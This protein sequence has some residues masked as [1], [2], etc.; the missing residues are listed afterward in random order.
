MYEARIIFT[1]DTVCPWTYIAKKK[2]DQALAQFRS[3]PASSSITYTLHFEPYQLSPSFPPGSVDR[4]EWHFEHKHKGM[5]EAEDAFQSQL[6]RRA[7]PVG[8]NFRFDGA[9]GN[10]LHAHRVIQYFQQAKGSETANKLIDALYT[11]Y[12]EQGL[13]PSE[14]ETLIASCIEAGISEEEAKKVVLDKELGLAEVQTKLNEVRRDIDA[15]PVAAIEGKKRD[16]T[17]TGSKEIEEYLRALERIA[18]ESS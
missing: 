8:I 18:K 9:M 11:R 16:I 10:T 1:L 7:E 12:F 6:R 4:K 2:L 15:V 14:D 3:S 5:V 17:L 13:H